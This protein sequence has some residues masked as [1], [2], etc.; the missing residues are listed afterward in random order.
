M[1]S[2]VHNVVTGK[3][4]WFVRIEKGA[5][6]NSSD[7]KVLVPFCTSF[8]CASSA[9]TTH[10]TG[11]HSKYKKAVSKVKLEKQNV[12]SIVLQNRSYIDVNGVLNVAF[13]KDE[14]DN[15]VQKK[16]ILWKEHTK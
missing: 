2:I 3:R 10:F 14:W 4:E 13:G 6:G 7:K 1:S 9:C 15:L 16:N 5:L 11:G 12:H 8:R